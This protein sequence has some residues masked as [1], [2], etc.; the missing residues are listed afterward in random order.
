M[1]TLTKTSLRWLLDWLERLFDNPFGPAW[2]PLRQLGTLAFF[3]FWVCAVSG[4]YVFI[5]FDTSVSGAF[6]SVEDLTRQWYLGGVMRSLHRYTSDAMVMTTGLHLLREFALDRYRGARWFSWF[7]G[8]PVIW[9][10]FISGISGYWLVWDQLAQYVAVGSMEWIDWIGIFGEPVA[11]N[12]LTRGSLDDRFF[13]LLVFIHIFGP[14]F[15]LFMMWVH[16]LRI[17]NAKTNPP[18]G[19]AIG[20]FLMMVGLS[21]A[22]PAL[23]HP[24]ADLG[25]VPGTL[26]LDW[27]YMFLYPAF[28]I[29]GP[30][31]LWAISFG[32]SLLLC[33]MPWLP[34]K[35]KADTPDVLLEQCNGCSRCFDDCPYGAVSMRPRTDGRPFEKEASVNPDLCTACGICVGACPMATPFRHGGKLLTGIDLPNL[36]L[37][38]L[39]E[40]LAGVIEKTRAGQTPD[41]PGIVVIGCAH[42]P[43]LGRVQDQATGTLSLPCIGMLPP[44]FLDF[45]LSGETVGGVMLTGCDDC[46]C[47]HRFGIPWT[48]DRIAGLRDPYLRKRVPRDRVRACWAGKGGTEKLRREIETFRVRLAAPAP[49]PAPEPAPATANNQD[50]EP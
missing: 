47:Y 24:P 45:A 39:Q 27:Y 40:T 4:I 14:L 37:S 42:G 30:G 5:L 6:T 10:L 48:K 49:E 7:T 41:R 28:D 22:Y 13:S 38:A 12:F 36:P 8:V 17:N 32:G 43:D 18:R 50:G 1:L 11:N 25:Q 26:N 23:S 33:V 21:F 29:W 31:A 16:I 3:F 19:L 2:N 20:S 15:L 46:D 34:P 44:S 9:L 35:K